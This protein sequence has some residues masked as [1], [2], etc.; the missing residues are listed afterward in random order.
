MRTWL[1]SSIVIAVAVAGVL[2]VVSLFV[3]R[4]AGQAGR[5]GRLDGHPN[6]SG[7]WQALNEADWDLEA[8]PARA[9][10]VTQVGVHPLAIV[11]AAPVPPALVPAARALQSVSMDQA[12][13]DE[14]QPQVRVAFGLMNLK[15]APWRPC[16]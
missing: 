2:V 12:A 4:S 9:G 14:P 10:M 1:R 13:N 7:V 11:P 3:T 15:P 5:V 8:H 16:T 6:F